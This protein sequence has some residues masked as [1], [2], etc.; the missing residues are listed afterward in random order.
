MRMCIFWRPSHFEKRNMAFL[1]CWGQFCWSL[2]V[3][4]YGSDTCQYSDVLVCTEGQLHWRASFNTQNAPGAFSHQRFVF[5][6][7]PTNE[8]QG[9]RERRRRERR[10][11]GVF[12]WWPPQ[13]TL[14]GGHSQ[15]V[16][17]S[18]NQILFWGGHQ[19]LVTTQTRF[20]G[21]SPVTPPEILGEVTGKKWPPP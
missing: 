18:P 21:R 1:S 15:M 5:R 10:K 9:F 12:A 19:I 13:T 3:A 8:W 4:F 17:P 2:T 20:W 6:R 7:S 16:T 11:I 14:G